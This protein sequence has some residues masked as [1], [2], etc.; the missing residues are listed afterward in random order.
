MVLHAGHFLFHFY[1]LKVSTIGLCVL[2]YFLLLLDLWSRPLLLYQFVLQR[3][4][5]LL[6]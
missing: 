1:Q 2:L 4:K 3:K 6:F 5:F